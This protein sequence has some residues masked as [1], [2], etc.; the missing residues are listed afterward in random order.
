MPIPEQDEVAF[1]GFE[2]VLDGALWKYLLTLLDEA[3]KAILDAIKRH[4]KL[5]KQTWDVAKGRLKLKRLEDEHNERKNELVEHMKQR[6]TKRNKRQRD[7]DVSETDSEQSSEFESDG[8]RHS[9]DDSSSTNSENSED[10]KSLSPFKKT[11][12]IKGTKK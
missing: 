10:D 11:S 6:A 4:S 9:N 7:E 8:W 5:S 1:Q 12:A 3:I 2:D